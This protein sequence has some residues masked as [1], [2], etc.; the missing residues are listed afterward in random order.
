MAYDWISEAVRLRVQAAIL[1]RRTIAEIMKL[2]KVPKRYVEEQRIIMKSGLG[3]PDVRVKGTG[4]EVRRLH[5]LGWSARQI[6][7]KLKVSPSYVY[8]QRRAKEKS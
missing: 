5:K 7:E 2:C 3:V 8:Q 4:A 6:A 1:Q